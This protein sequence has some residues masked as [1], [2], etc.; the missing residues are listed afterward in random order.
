MNIGRAN[1]SSHWKLSGENRFLG[2][3]EELLHTTMRTKNIKI[4]IYLYNKY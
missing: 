3:L 2:P 4:R 1:K